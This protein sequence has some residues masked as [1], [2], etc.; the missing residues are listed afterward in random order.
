MAVNNGGNRP[1]SSLQLLYVKPMGSVIHRP[2]L[3]TMMNLQCTL[4]EFMEHS[5]ADEGVTLNI[6]CNGVLIVLLRV[7][8]FNIYG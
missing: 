5:V 8:I 3:V 6:D 1:I 4:T 7:N 2:G